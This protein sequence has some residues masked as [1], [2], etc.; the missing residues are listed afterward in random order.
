MN[1][2]KSIVLNATEEKT[3]KE[4]NK[5]NDS[6]GETQWL[7]LTDPKKYAAQICCCVQRIL[8]P[9]YLEIPGEGQRY[10]SAQ[11]IIRRSCW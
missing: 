3:Q 10:I 11:V 7:E 2:W 6:V 9:M 4:K 8:V 1:V 5:S